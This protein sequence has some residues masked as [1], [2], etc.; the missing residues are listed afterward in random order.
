MQQIEGE[1]IAKYVIVCLELSLVS[2]GQLYHN[3][4]PN[5]YYLDGVAEE[6][7]EALKEA[8]QL[9]ITDLARRFNLT[10]EYIQVLVE[11]RLGRVI[12]GTLEKGILYT[13]A[14]VERYRSQIRGI[15]A[16]ITK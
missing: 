15:F 4:I 3:Y 8:G 6:I 16:A 7:E 14:F 1:L 2:F 5:S 9:T 13:E 12:H 10:S 11:R